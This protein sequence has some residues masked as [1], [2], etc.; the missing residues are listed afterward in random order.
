M[1]CQPS[2]VI[3]YNFGVRIFQCKTDLDQAQIFGMGMATIW[4][5][6]GS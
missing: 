1:I 6:F 2:N 3:G 5:S 4:E